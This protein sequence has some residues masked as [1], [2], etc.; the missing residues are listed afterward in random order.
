[1]L[2]QAKR[3]GLDWPEPAEAPTWRLP[4][5]EPGKQGGN[6]FNAL[7]PQMQTMEPWSSRPAAEATQVYEAALR[8]NPGDA[9]SLS[10][11][12]FLKF[13]T[14][15]AAE[16]ADLQARAQ[17]LCPQEFLIIRNGHFFAGM[18]EF[19]LG[20]D[21]A[22]YERMK[23]T[24][25]IRPTWGFAWQWMAAIDALAGRPESAATNLAQFRRY[26]PNQTI[27]SLRATE[28]SRNETF[29][30]EENRFYEG[31]RKAGLPE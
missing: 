5:V 14:G 1:M 20:H 24:L 18:A 29:W 15:H 8:L 22:A 3:Q 6:P 23:M 9:Y 19:H 26:I 27:S 25:V 16:V 17:R 10:R 21:D 13:Q 28:M 12:G 30:V 31:L 4:R 11:L 7:R 2:W